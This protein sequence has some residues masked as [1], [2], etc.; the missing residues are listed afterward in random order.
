[1]TIHIVFND[2]SASPTAPDQT[3][4]KRYLDDFSDILVDRRIKGKKVLVTPQSFQQLQVSVGYPLGRWLKEYK[5]GDHDKRVLIKTLIDRSIEYGECTSVD[6][7]E[8]Q[9]VEYRYRDGPAEGLSVAS[10]VDGLAVS[11]RS[12][13]QW[14]VVSVSLEYSWIAEEQLETRILSVLHASQP[15]HLEAHLGWLRRK[16]SP[17]PA[18]GAEL[19]AERATVF[20]SLDFCESVEDQIKTLGGNDPRFKVI[21]RGLQELQSYCDSWETEYFDIH[22]LAKASGESR[23]TLDRFS[24]ERT[25]RCPDGEYR[26]F[27]WHLKRGNNTRIHF[28]DFPEQKR[29]LVGYIGAHLSIASQ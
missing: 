29:L 22:Q 10:F 1:M 13:D 19:W 2:L 4:A 21:M 6:L 8:R 25:I 26:V 15:D 23:S 27:E 28:V 12:S 7:V 16:Q 20:P 14:D 18:S 24:D 17:L 9:E 11:F 5:E 3:D